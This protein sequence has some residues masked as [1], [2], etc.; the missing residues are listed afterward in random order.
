[1]LE[2]ERIFH[3]KIH[4]SAVTWVDCG[5]TFPREEVAS[6]TSPTSQTTN[7]PRRPRIELYPL[8]RSVTANE[9]ANIEERFAVA[10]NSDT[11]LYLEPSE[12]QAPY[13]PQMAYGIW[14]PPFPALL[15]TSS[16][17]EDFQESFACMR[18]SPRTSG[19]LIVESIDGFFPSNRN[20]SPPSRGSSLCCDLW[21]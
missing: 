2:E 7:S 5:S 1:M 6:A 21:S 10:D 13:S 11:G 12:L 4:Y 14:G 9:R 20:Y 16:R 15:S 19:C 3:R 17:R 18:G 8:K